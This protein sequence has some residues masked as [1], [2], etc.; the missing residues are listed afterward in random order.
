M[1]GSSHR[2]EALMHAEF[3]GVQSCHI[4]RVSGEETHEVFAKPC[5]PSCELKVAEVQPL[6]SIVEFLN[7]CVACERCV[8]HS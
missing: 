4:A 6:G 7:H 8:N 1:E 3:G 5:M 2:I